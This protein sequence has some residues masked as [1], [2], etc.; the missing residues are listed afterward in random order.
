MIDHDTGVRSANT[1][2]PVLQRWTRA[3]HDVDEQAQLLPGWEQ[4]YVQLEPGRFESRIDGVLL[5]GA[6][7]LFRKASNRKLHKT[8]STPVDTYA[9]A[10]ITGAS[11][12]ISFQ[13]CDATRGD[14]LLLPPGHVYDIV[15]RGYF[16]VLV[17]TLPAARLQLSGP[18]SVE[19]E[20]VLRPGVA[21]AG[22][23]FGAL[24]ALLASMVDSN[25]G[26][27]SDAALNDRVL[28]HLIDDLEDCLIGRLD[29]T[30][31]IKSAF[32][33]SLSEAALREALRILTEAALDF[34]EVPKVSELARRLGVSVRSLHYVF[35][36]RMGTSPRSYAQSLRLSRARADLRVARPGEVTVAE[37]A[38]K[39]GFWHLGRFAATYRSTFGELPSESLRH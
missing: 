11:E 2:A 33:G 29:G 24:G 23:E 31:G 6:L 3:S 22:S 17:A 14:A 20:C 26:T 10:L 19:R 36:Q 1:A 38:V 5:P 32:A 34:G 16:D 4:D 15:C 25:L 12:S 21:R 35:R 39:W 8:F 28:G 37:V 7:G 13:G 30:T 18:R 27:L 9:V